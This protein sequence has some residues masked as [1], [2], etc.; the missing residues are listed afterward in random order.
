VK[1]L[2]NATSARLGGGI[3][4]LRNLLPALLAGSSHSY[5]V[6]SRPEVARQIDP[7]DPRMRF[8]TLTPRARPLWE[9]LAL[10]LRRCDALFS[11][12]NVAVFGA[13]APQVLMFQNALPFDRSVLRRADPRRRLRLSALRALGIASAHKA[14]RIVFL[15]EQARALTLPH[16]H[17][18]PERT[19]V[20]HLGRDPAF[21]P[22][23]PPAPGARA[24][25]VSQ[26]YFYK[27]IVEL[28]AAFALAA[29]QLPPGAALDIAGAMP[30]PAYAREVKRQIARLGLEARV[31]LLGDVPHGE[32][33][34]LYARARLFLFPSTCESFPNILLEALSCGAPSIVS[35]LGP[36]REIAGDAAEYVDP[37][38]PPQ[39][40]LQIA[41]LW[42]DDARRAELRQRAVARAARFSWASTAAGILRALE[43]ATS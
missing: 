26:L 3:T 37:F 41:A 43:E 40:A 34:R 18:P 11:P 4:V 14:R 21:Q 5:T 9:Q 30:E 32:L 8:E 12:A 38:D 1:I 6:V 20:V 35:R 13:T 27:N 2:I 16:L 10:P 36:M 15:S 33:A 24:L 7:R 17:V 31:R 23:E 28:I 22:C 29:P 39:M 42:Q 19:S 25:C